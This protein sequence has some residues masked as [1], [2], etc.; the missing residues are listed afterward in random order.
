MF[1]ERH[2]R[3]PPRAPPG[4]S[5]RAKSFEPGN[6]NPLAAPLARYPG[7]PMTLALRD[8]TTG[9]TLHR[10]PTADR[11]A[12]ALGAGGQVFTAL[13]LDV[14]F[15][16][17]R[18]VGAGRSLA[19]TLSIAPGELHRVAAEFRDVMLADGVA[20][21]LHQGQLV[22]FRPQDH[23]VA[24]VLTLLEVLGRDRLAPFRQAIRDRYGAVFEKRSIDAATNE[25][26]RRDLDGLSDLDGWE[27]VARCE[28][29]LGY[30][31]ESID[32]AWP[33]VSALA[34]ALMRER[35]LAA[36]EALAIVEDTPPGEP[37][38]QW[39]LRRERAGLATRLAFGVRDLVW[40]LQG[41]SP[42][43]PRGPSE[44]ESI[45]DL[46]RNHPLRGAAAG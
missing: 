43:V 5:P 11:W 42:C 38:G 4:R 45:R 24:L 32:R 12:V 2:S 36:W 9:A 6:T 40:E 10:H 35:Y 16:S 18:L 29:I 34:R 22:R 33:A 37:L 41:R 19:S 26:G 7:R 44:D 3:T 15:T 31:S 17:V 39:Q 8:G 20:R 28:T 25:R 13:R 21:Y 30:V 46:V 23:H 27:V 1:E 14:R